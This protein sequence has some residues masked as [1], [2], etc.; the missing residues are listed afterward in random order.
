MRMLL[1]KWGLDQVPYLV[2]LIDAGWRILLVLLLAW[3]LWH[4]A[5]RLIGLARLRLTVRAAGPDDTKRIQTMTQVFRYAVG[6]VLSIVTAMLVLGEL[7]ISIAPLLATAGVAGVA[8][9]FGVQSL[10]KDYFT[11]FALLFENQVR[12]GDVVEAGGK[13]GMVE[14][15]TLRYIRL[16]DYD[17]VVH[18]V[19]N[20]LV[21]TV[22]NMT[23]G[24]A[25][26]VIEIG[27]SYFADI[28]EAFRIMRE[29]TVELRADPAFGPKILEDMEIAGVE[30][31]SESSVMLKARIKTVPLEQWSVRREYLRRLKGAFDAHGIEIPFPHLTL[32]PGSAPSRTG[33]PVQVSHG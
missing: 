2:D 14:E 27:V 31:L 29:Q 33:F 26:A 8:L 5:S 18:F 21:S 19:P 9:G 23:M 24:F 28:D 25:Y 30:S 15:V 6:V 22:S 12:Q 17:G 3:L 1:N 13:T 32:Y 16:R 11:G 10:V 7:G 4:V 20:G